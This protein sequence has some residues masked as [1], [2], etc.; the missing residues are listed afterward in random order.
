MKRG[1]ALRTDMGCLVREASLACLSD[2]VVVVA[3]VVDKS[4]GGCA[5][6]LGLVSRRRLTGAVSSTPRPDH[7]NRGLALSHVTLERRM[8][9]E[10]TLVAEQAGGGTAASK[11][12]SIRSD[13][14]FRI[15]RPLRELTMDNV[16]HS[17]AHELSI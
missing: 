10:V 5:P 6:L 7:G 16:Q 14:L 9:R 11:S 4:G 2:D 15:I 17:L 8:E 1:R 13:S 3:V 12:M